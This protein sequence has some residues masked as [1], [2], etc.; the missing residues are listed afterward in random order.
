MPELE[1]FEAEVKAK[2][3]QLAS[4]DAN[5]RRKAAEWLGEAGDPMAITALAQ[6]YKNDSDP[7]VRAAAGYSL[8]MFR[9]LEAALNSDKADQM[10]K[11]LADV[12]LKGKF[13]RRVPWPVK[14]MAK[15]M[16]ALVLSALFIAA[17]SFVLPGILRGTATTAS[18]PEAPTAESQP[19]LP[20]TDPQ[21]GALLD[22]DRPALTLKL[23]GA[24]ES[25]TASATQLQAQYQSVLGGGTADCSL[26]FPAQEPLALSPANTSNFPD[27]AGAANSLNQIQ[28]DFAAAKSLY[29]R[30]CAGEAI[31]PGDYGAPMGQVVAVL[32]SLSAVQTTLI[33]ETAPTTV[34]AEALSTPTPEVDLR[35]HVLALQTIIDDM[36]ALRGANSILNQFWTESTSGTGTTGCTSERPVL[37][38]DY[39]LPE[40]VAAASPDLA[41]VAGLVNTGLGA[42]RQSWALFDA[43]CAAGSP[44]VNAQQG[45]TLTQ[46]ASTAFSSA[47][48]ELNKVRG[49]A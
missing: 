23:Q 37:P 43:G 25:L 12:A 20:T 38:A 17:A 30:T 16:L 48:T 33:G 24:L 10:M 31:P 49:G 27:L 42:V 6:A 18:Q 47:T 34:P 7:R 44:G 41:L 2:L 3:K 11:V 28:V 19:V 32:Q 14:R 1:V 39:V 8:G 45:L 35:T 4:K 40:D 46:A 22:L 15:L 26:V 21:A 5:A 29:D 9:S 36:T 13:G